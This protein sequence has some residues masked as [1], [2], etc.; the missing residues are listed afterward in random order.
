MSDLV[1]QVKL[2]VGADITDAKKQFDALKSKVESVHKDIEKQS[3]TGGKNVGDAFGKALSTTTEKWTNLTKGVL[4]KYFGETGRM[5]SDGIENWDKYKKAKEASAKL[6]SLTENG[7]T[8]ISSAVAG[9][10]GGLMSKIGSLGGVTVGTAAGLGIAATAGVGLAVGGI[11][12]LAS[13][14][15]KARAREQEM[16]DKTSV[17]DSINSIKDPIL[18]QQAIL[19]EFGVDGI[20]VFDALTQEVIKFQKQLQDGIAWQTVTENAKLT[21]EY[22]GE[23]WSDLASLLGSLWK[24]LGHLGGKMAEMFGGTDQTLYEKDIQELNA[25]HQDVS[26]QRRKKLEFDRKKIED[27]LV[28]TAIESEYNKTYNRET[29]PEQKLKDQEKDLNFISNGIYRLGKNTNPQDQLNFLQ[30]W[31]TVQDSRKQMGL[32]ALVASPIVKQQL[33]NANKYV[34]QGMN[35]ETEDFLSKK[36]RED[37]AIRIIP[38]MGK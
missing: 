32:P 36:Y 35:K 3:S 13:G 21:T 31:N 33:A 34:V 2:L 24:G 9:G 23:T 5:V 26:R 8:P 28:R 17:V 20:K 10:T 25:S 11:Y 18:R 37:G 19:K 4:S 30:Q 15:S 7:G 27:K 12:G 22:I 38:Q 16:F 14:R 29:S 1:N 6:E